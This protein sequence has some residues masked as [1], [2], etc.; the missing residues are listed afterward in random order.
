M[1]GRGRSPCG[2][3]P[4]LPELAFAIGPA[5]EVAYKV[6]D[7][8]LSSTSLRRHD[9][10]ARNLVGR[11]GIEPPGRRSMPRLRDL[12]HTPGLTDTTVAVSASSRE[13]G[14]RT[15]SSSMT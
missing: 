4:K 5:G 15:S 14:N 9:S 3:W 2:R 10:A 11:D 12:A 7:G 8:G 1:R 13:S 6:I